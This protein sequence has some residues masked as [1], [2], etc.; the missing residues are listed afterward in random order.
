MVGECARRLGD[1]ETGRLYLRRALALVRELGHRGQFPELLQ[2]IAAV[3]DSRDVAAQLLAAADRL[4]RE[5]DLPRWDP[6]DLARTI[7]LVRDDLGPDFTTAWEAGAGLTEE[8]ALALA[9]RC[10]E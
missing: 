1:V 3:A 10:L 8:E 7:E 6:E 9:D 4:S 2:E 5:N